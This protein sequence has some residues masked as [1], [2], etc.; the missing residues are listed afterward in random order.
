[1]FLV[2]LSFPAQSYVSVKATYLHPSE[3]DSSLVYGNLKLDFS[4]I[5]TISLYLI[6]L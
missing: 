6:C 2:P 4:I 3:V 5:V 1:M